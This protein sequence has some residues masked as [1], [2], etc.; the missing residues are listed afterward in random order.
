MLID[1]NSFDECEKRLSKLQEVAFQ[2][3]KSQ[4]I[5]KEIQKIKEKLTD[6][7]YIKKRK[8]RFIELAKQ[9]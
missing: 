1:L 2:S 8:E 5:Y 6:P 3:E 7:L 9:K 4:L